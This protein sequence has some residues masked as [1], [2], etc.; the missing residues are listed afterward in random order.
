MNDFPNSSAKFLVPIAILLVAAFAIF[1]AMTVIVQSGNVG[2]ITTLGAVQPNALPEGFHFKKPFI[3]SVQQIDIRLTASHAQATAASKD[4]Q[5]VTTQV[6]M[7]YSL[8]GALAPQ[9]YQ[10]IGLLS[11]VSASLV[12]PAIQ[13]CV[14]GVTAK[15]T[16]EELVTKRELVKQQIQDALS[17]FINNTL[18]EKGLENAV[19][20]ANLAITDFNFSPEFNRAIEAKVK[21]EQ[22]ALQ[23]KN[24]KI[25]RVTQAEAS[26]EERKLAASAEAFSTEVQSK[27]RADAIQREALALKQSP[28]I[29]Q[30]RSIEKWDGVLPR[31]SGGGVVPF[32]NVGD[33]QGN[34]SSGS[35]PVVTPQR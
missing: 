28:E 12:E 1:S 3:D 19:N 4:L 20:I 21:A 35:T 5:S 34:S 30:L 8:N 14:K 15:F 9:I 25:M 10:R 2:V 11:K 22:M 18:R 33:M 16:A 32:L 26:A 24:E 6:T 27:A 23:A 13:E 31:I 29:I 7:Q 17:H